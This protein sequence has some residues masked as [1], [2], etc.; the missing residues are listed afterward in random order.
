[1]SLL[2]GLVGQPTPTVGPRRGPTVVACLGLLATALLLAGCGTGGKVAE[3]SPP[4]TGSAPAP[5]GDPTGPVAGTGQPGGSG[6][7]SL[8][9]AN[10]VTPQPVEQ[11]RPLPWSSAVPVGDGTSLAVSFALGPPTCSLLGGVR[12]EESAA[13]VTVT[14]TVGQRPGADCSGPQPAIAFPAVT[15]VHLAAALAGR[16][17]VDGAR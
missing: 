14:L 3:P 13:A 1:M 4:A 10:P 17:V 8:P 6:D 12:V 9:G 16:R 7:P 11:P 2:A 5:G 15:T